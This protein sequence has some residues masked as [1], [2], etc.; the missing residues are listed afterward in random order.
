MSLRTGLPL[1]LAA[2]SFEAAGLG[3][4]GD[5]G[6]T[7][8]AGT[9]TT[10]GDPITAGNNESSGDVTDPGTSGSASEP[11]TTDPSGTTDATTTIDP[12][13][14]TDVPAGCGDGTVD[15]GEEC[16]AG[17][18]NGDD[19][20]CTAGCKT[21]VCGDG[22]P[23]P[24]EGCDDGNMVPDDGCSPMCASES[25][26]DNVKQPEEDCDDGNLIN[27][28]DCTNACTLPACGDGFVQAGEQCDTG[29][30][31]AACNSDCTTADCGD[32]VL[33][34]SAGELC[35]DN[36]EDTTDNCP[37]CQPAVCGDG[38]VQAALESCD[39]GNNVDADACSNT[40]V[41]NG[42][43][44][45]VSSS[46][47]S[48]NLGGLGS[49]DAKCKSLADAA[50]LG[51]TWMAWLSD[52]LSSPSGRFMSKGGPRLYVRLDGKIVANNW[53]ALVSMPLLAPIDITEKKLPAGNA[54][55]VWT[56]TKPDG[57]V[58]TGL[59][60]CGGWFSANGNVDGVN[61]RRT[62]MDAKWTQEGDDQCNAQ[63][64][65]YCFEQ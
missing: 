3:S 32:G 26:G 57:T 38:F 33:N 27:E 7:S 15:A 12:S 63:N 41:L 58:A 52:G 17:P 18:M 55:H 56:N 39:D 44:V 36:N 61:G 1:L 46:V 42:L 59:Q 30:E 62:D 13:S 53:A 23:G 21:N 11:T 64:R 8:S 5:G 2:C 9:G 28:D 4:N 35:D 22:K 10:T 40:C 49:A 24:G 14:T 65:L 50:K 20:A 43:R 6:G 48:G 45:F 19:K 51:G 29:G 16:D 54:D 34:M 47:Y 37:A 31:T 60:N 25:C